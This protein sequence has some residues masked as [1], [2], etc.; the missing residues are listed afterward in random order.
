MKGPNYSLFEI[1]ETKYELFEFEVPKVNLHEFH[2]QKCV[3]HSFIFF[4]IVN[5]LIIFISFN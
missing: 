1:S 4:F 5:I 2:G 3:L